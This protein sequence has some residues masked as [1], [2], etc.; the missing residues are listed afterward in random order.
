MLKAPILQPPTV[1]DYIAFEEHASA[2]YTR[3]MQSPR[4]EVWARLPIFYFSTPLRIFGPDAEIPFP[5]ASKQLD[6]E[7][8]LA[9]IIGREAINVLEQQA[10]ACIAGF[11]IFN[12]WSARDVQADESE[13]GLGPAKG[14]GAASSLGLWIVTADEIAANIAMAPSTWIARCGST[15]SCGWTATPGT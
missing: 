2:H 10:D 13:F 15:G 11:T 9:A 1:R 6:Y 5:S 4:M 3:D 7:C 8:E 12:D 14:K